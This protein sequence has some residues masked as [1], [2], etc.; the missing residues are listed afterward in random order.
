MSIY[1][2]RG[3]EL[4]EVDRVI[5]TPQGRR[6]VVVGAGGFLGLGRDQ[7]AF[8]LERFGMR[9]DRLVIRV[10]TEDDIEAMD[11]YRDT[12]DNFQRVSRNEQADCGSGSKR[13]FGSVRTGLGDHPQARAACEVLAPR[14]A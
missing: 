8:A 10:V 2:G 9:G 4:G 1:N 11:D 14:L 5:V 6:F 12:L 3:E 7:M 13:L